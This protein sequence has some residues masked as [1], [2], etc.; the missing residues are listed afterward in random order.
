MASISGYE[1]LIRHIE[2]GFDGNTPCCSCY[3]VE[4]AIG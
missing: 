3:D 4:G 2:S 1:G